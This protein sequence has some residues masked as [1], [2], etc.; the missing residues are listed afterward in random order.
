MKNFHGTK[1]RECY[2]KAQKKP[3]TQ[4][5]LAAFG[6]G[7]VQAIN[8][9]TAR[10]GV[11]EMKIGGHDTDIATLRSQLSGMDA[12][13]KQFQAAFKTM[14][15]TISLMRNTI[16]TLERRAQ[17][18]EAAEVK[19][20]SDSENEDDDP[21]SDTV[22]DLLQGLTQGGLP[23]PSEPSLSAAVQSLMPPLPSIPV[24]NPGSKTALIPHMD[25]NSP[26]RAPLPPPSASRARSG[27]P[28]SIPAVAA[29]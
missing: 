12:V 26:L 8:T 6:Q 14:E 5:G 29:H 2:N 4:Q 15:G 20:Q 21:T 28:S 10:I 13:V 27:L 19:R 11:T 16:E 17:A 25:P 9:S 18:A 3:V 7:V 24:I 23:L 1:C 22:R